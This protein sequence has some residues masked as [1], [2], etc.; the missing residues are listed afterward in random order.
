VHREA[1][2]ARTHA[3]GWCSSTCIGGR[4]GASTVAAAR[5]QQRA[6]AGLRWPWLL[7]AIAAIAVP[8]ALYLGLSLGSLDDLIVRYGD[9]SAVSGLSLD[10]AEGTMTALVGPNGAGKSTLLK[11]LA[12]VLQPAAGERELGYQVRA[13]YFAQHRHEMLRA[14]ATVL[15][16][17][18]DGAR[19]TT[20]ATA[21]PR[22]RQRCG[23]MMTSPTTMRSRRPSP[24]WGVKIGKCGL[25]RC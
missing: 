4:R 7:T 6:P 16:A 17:A 11:L 23:F 18:M 1:C 5:P 3:R 8:W 20:A 15:E 24:S 12:G 9:R 19:A 14:D 13:G 2:A 22:L 21:A 10:V 25:M